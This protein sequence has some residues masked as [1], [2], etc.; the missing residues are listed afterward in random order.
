MCKG[1]LSGSQRVR[2]PQPCEARP[3]RPP[4]TCQPTPCGDGCPLGVVRADRAQMAKTPHP[5]KGYGA[6]SDERVRPPSTRALEHDTIVPPYRH[7]Q[8]L[9][10]SYRAVFSAAYTVSCID[11]AIRP[12]HGLSW[13]HRASLPDAQKWQ[14]AIAVAYLPESRC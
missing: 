6:S 14:A 13:S 10:G 4:P 11:L 3:D 7:S 1:K 8:R 5:L 2:H 9:T 12:R